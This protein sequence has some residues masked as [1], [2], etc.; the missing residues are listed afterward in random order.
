ME[1][2]FVNPRIPEQTLGEF[3]IMKAAE[4]I[5]DVLIFLNMIIL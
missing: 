1:D 4:N 2:Q 3:K 5:G